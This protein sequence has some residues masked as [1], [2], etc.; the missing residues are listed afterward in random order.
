MILK[1]P[2]QQFV[3]E[4]TSSHWYFAMPDGTVLPRH[5]ADLR[6]AR[7]EKLFPSPT[8]IEKDI[9]ANPVLNR[10]IKNQ[11]AK[12]FVNNPRLPEEQDD[13]Y[14]ARILTISDSV[15]DE[16]A[17]RGTALHAAIETGGTDDMV[18]AP[19]YQAYIPWHNDNIDLTI[20]SEVK[21]A[22][23]QLGVAGTVDRIVQHKQHGL[24]ILDYKTQKVKKG[25]AAFY[26]SF[27]RQLSFYAGAYYRKHNVLPRIMSV[28]IDSQVPSRPQ[29]KLYTLEEQAQAYAEFQSHVFLWCSDRDYWPTGRWSP[30]FPL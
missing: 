18:L 4:E 19:F 8:T 20:G 24:C 30:S 2:T 1:S 17:I 11:V 28:V 14:A 23:L 21:M 22:D 7:K 6:I 13:A 26:E 5:D 25:K 16:A 12:A 29:E 15:R 10:W 3:K 9:R 27:P